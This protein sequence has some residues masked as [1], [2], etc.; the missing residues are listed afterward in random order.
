MLATLADHALDD[1]SYVY[2]PKYDGIRALAALEP[3]RKGPSIQLLSRLGNEKSVQFPEIVEALSERFTRRTSPLVLDGEIVALDPQGNPTTFQHLQG[4]I[5]DLS[6]T[7]DAPVAFVLFDVLR[8]GQEDLRDLPLSERRQR[9]VKLVGQAGSPRL[10]LSEQV[11]GDGRGLWQQAMSHGWE[12]LIAKRASSPYRT[13]KRSP[14]WIKLKL[15]AEQEFVIGGW[16]EARGTRAYFGALL[17]GVHEPDGSLTYV[18]HA[19]TGFNER[20]LK[21]VSALLKPLEIARCPFSERPKTNERAHWVQPKLVAQVKFTEWTDD[22]KLRHPTYL[23]LRDDVNPAKVRRE[24]TSTM[25]RRS[26]IGK[27]AAPARSAAKRPVALD[28]NLQQLVDMLQDLE[29]RR[30]DGI[31]QLPDGH[32]LKV[33]NLQKVFWPEARVTKGDLLR[34]Y[35]R[36]AP[37]ILPVVAD[38]PL[39]MK[40]FPNGIHGQSFYQQRAPEQVPAGVR[41]EVLPD[42]D[43]P[44][45]IVGGSLTTLLYMAQLAVIS[46]DPW[47][48]RVQSPAAVDFVAIDLDPPEGVT[49]AQ[50]LDVARWVRDELAMLGAPSF[51]KTS[52]SDGLHV[53]LPMPPDTPYEAGMLFCQIVATM[54]AMKHPKQATVERT[55]RA[56][57]KGTVY[58]DYLQNIEGK[59]LACAY[60]ARASEWAG[61]STPVTWKEI[62]AGFDR[63]DF[64]M[65]NLPDRIAQVGDLWEGLRTSKPVDLRS[66]ERYAGGSASGKDVKRKVRTRA[67]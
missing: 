65:R 2:E 31:L 28:A 5:H 7:G 4:R 38:R 36:V 22:A 26:A 64:T 60:S 33:S 39:V 8:D 19:G 25:K 18:G 44:S 23:G 14:D 37:Y 54:V 62:D 52:G 41:I 47:F 32:Q 17:L 27:P 35:L 11:H 48:S 66:I 45:R 13:G 15:V 46:Q 40:R 59:T 3:G 12:G 61:A 16:T 24:P 20:E 43:V 34:Y 30:K 67:R 10:R 6:G 51:P 55:V 29:T 50:V 49:F 1:R 56:R 63:Q 9:L 42:D 53:F 57:P 21:K 58:V